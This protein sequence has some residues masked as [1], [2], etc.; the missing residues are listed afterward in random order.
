MSD[1]LAFEAQF[2]RIHGELALVNTKL[3]N[4]AEW[5]TKELKGVSKTL[6]DLRELFHSLRK[7]ANDIA[8]AVR[9]DLERQVGQVAGD[10]DEHEQHPHPHTA[11]EQAVDLRFTAHS[12]ALNKVAKRTNEQDGALKVLAW[13]GGIIATVT[14]LL[15][16]NAATHFL[17][18]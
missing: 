3:D 10:L 5:R 1:P 14:A 17:G 2:E 15:I 9:R 8:S 13:L 16:V 12:E 4:E 7:E 6:E 18:R 11:W